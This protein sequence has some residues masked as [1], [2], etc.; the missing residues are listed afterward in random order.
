MGVCCNKKYLT[1]IHL[2]LKSREISFVHN[3]MLSCQIIFKFSTEHGSVTAM[4]CANCQKDLT[5]EVDDMEE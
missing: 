5:T 4:L 1:E 3:L 2:K